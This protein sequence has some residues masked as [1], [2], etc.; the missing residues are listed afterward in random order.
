MTRGLTSVA[1]G[2]VNGLKTLG[3]KIAG[4]PSVLI[5]SVVG[6]IFKTAG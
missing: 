6:F 1:K 4:I 2:V 3:S 5:G